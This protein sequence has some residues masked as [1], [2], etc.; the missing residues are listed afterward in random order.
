M[1]LTKVDIPFAP[2]HIRVDWDAVPGATRYEVYHRA[3]T[4][5]IR[6]RGQRQH[7]V[8][9]RPVP[10]IPSYDSYVVRACSAAGC[11]AFSASVTEN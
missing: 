9:P 3:A 10:D 11:S 8:L 1:G 7:D 2:D 5:S 6:L 4:A